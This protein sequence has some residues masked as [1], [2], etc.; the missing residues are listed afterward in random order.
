MDGTN[1]TLYF[2]IAHLGI[3]MYNLTV[4]RNGIQNKGSG[5]HNDTIAYVNG[6]II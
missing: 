5:Q 1:L 6:N 2:T 3:H 4:Y